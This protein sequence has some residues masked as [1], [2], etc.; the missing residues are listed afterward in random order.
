MKDV[1]KRRRVMER[2]MRLGH[3]ICDPKKPCPCEMLKA[4]DVCCAR[5]SALSGAG[6]AGAADAAC[7]EAGCASKIDQAALKGVLAAAADC[8]R[9]AGAGRRCGGRRRGGVSADGRRGYGAD[10]GRVLAVGGRPYTF[11]QIAAANSVS[12][13][14]AMGGTPLTALSIVG[15]PIRTVPDECLRDP[16]GRDGQDGGGGGGGH[17]RAQH[18]G[19]GDQGGLRGDGGDRP[20][21]RS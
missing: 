19:R 20:E 7:G 18:Q 1:E 15:F 16:A 11:G 10:G 5:A 9:P 3:C 17:R 14:Y 21:A 4:Q 2:S 6:R 8:R 12:D 13:I